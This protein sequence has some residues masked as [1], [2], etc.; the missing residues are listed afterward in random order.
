MRS[1]LYSLLA[2]AFVLTTLATPTVTLPRNEGGKPLSDG[3]A[4]AA[5]NAAENIRVRESFQKR[6]TTNAQILRR[7]QARNVLDIVKRTSCKDTT[8]PT[9]SGR[10]YPTCHE[11]AGSGYAKY[12]GW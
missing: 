7:R 5:A 9:T 8:Y 11:S 2:L 3:A 4:S 6:Q 1:F 12:P 10:V